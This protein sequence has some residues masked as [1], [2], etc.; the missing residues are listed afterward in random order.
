MEAYMSWDSLQ[1]SLHSPLIF[2]QCAALQGQG[3]DLHV[4]PHLGSRLS[5]LYA[6]V[7]TKHLLEAVF[8][9]VECRLYTE[10]TQKARWCFLLVMRGKTGY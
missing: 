1:T 8:Q 7:S 4:G 6:C 2:L 5:V 9:V 10:L 3:L